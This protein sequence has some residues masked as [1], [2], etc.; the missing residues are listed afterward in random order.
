MFDGFHINNSTSQ[1]HSFGATQVHGSCVTV[2]LR[3]SLSPCCHRWQQQQQKCNSSSGRYRR[4]P[5]RAL[6]TLAK[7]LLLPLTLDRATAK[8]ETWEKE[9]NAAISNNHSENATATVFSESFK[10][11]Q[12]LLENTGH[13]KNP[14]HTIQSITIWVSTVNLS[15]LGWAPAKFP[16]AGDKSFLI[17]VNRAMSGREGL[18]RDEK[19][20]SLG[21]EILVI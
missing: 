11:Y 5:R 18:L 14:Y 8:M 13:L 17:A 12:H 3:N 9:P 10:D 15:A 21:G 1:H 6:F 16:S 2:F 19:Y 7:L 20:K 4:P